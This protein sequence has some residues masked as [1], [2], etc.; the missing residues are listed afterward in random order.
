MT[1]PQ[2]TDEMRGPVASR[3]TLTIERKGGSRLASR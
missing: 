2:T 3:I 1:L